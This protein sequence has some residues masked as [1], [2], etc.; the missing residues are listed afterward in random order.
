MNFSGTRILSAL[1]FISI[2]TFSVYGQAD[3]SSTAVNDT[4]AVKAHTPKHNLFVSGSFGSNM[5][6]LGSSISSNNPYYGTG[7]VY[8]YRNE[9]FLSA[10]AT[11]IQGIDPFCAFYSAAA[12][13]KHTFNKWFDISAELAGY[14]TNFRK[15]QM[16]F[17][18]FSYAGL[19]AGF[20]WKILYTRVTGSLIYSGQ[21]KGYLQVSNSR[22]FQSPY[23]FRKKA[24]VSFYPE[25]NLLMGQIVK[26]ENDLGNTMHSYIP[27]FMRQ[28]RDQPVPVMTLSTRFAPVY[29]NFSA[30]LTF[31]YNRFSIEADPCYILPAYSDDMIQ[32][33]KGFTFY[34]TASFRIF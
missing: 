17:S 1:L 9:F 7:L 5:I 26:V 6:F 3:S 23:F 20:D 27:P 33:P 2:G 29:V 15:S 13:Y 24:F 34:L 25:I 10:S 19:T 11:H 4:V 31:T 22:Y 12:D 16:P 14:S 30:P 21:T 32:L 8:G 18:S 28:R